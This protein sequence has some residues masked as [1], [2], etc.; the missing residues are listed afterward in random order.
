[1]S[2]TTHPARPAA[3]H[4]APAA[5]GPGGATGPA[6]GRRQPAAQAV[7]LT[8][9]AL[10]GWALVQELRTPADQRT[11]HGTVAGFV[12]YDLRPPTSAR[13]RERMWAPEDPRLIQPRVFGAGWTLNLGRL[14]FLLQ[15]RL[16]DRRQR[17]APA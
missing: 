15:H 9:I 3:E 6:A 2:L 5:S 13:F 11:W 8:G 1:M 12:P 4:A 17:R 7:R 10:A 16:A 14:V